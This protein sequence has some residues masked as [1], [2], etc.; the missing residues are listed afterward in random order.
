[1]RT[2]FPQCSHC[3]TLFGCEAHRT[4]QRNSHLLF[5]CKAPKNKTGHNSHLFNANAR[6]NRQNKNTMKFTLPITAAAAAVIL[7]AEGISAHCRSS[8]NGNN[9]NSGTCQLLEFT[10]Q[11]ESGPFYITLTPDSGGPEI[12]TPFVRVVS[13]K[14]KLCVALPCDDGNQ[15]GSL[16]VTATD[17]DD[18]WIGRGG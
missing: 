4:Q 12:I 14:S 2:L 8:S 7:T 15:I 17:I 10:R 18:T 9:G 5:G 11:L 6:V 1:M 16:Y 3:L 13:Q